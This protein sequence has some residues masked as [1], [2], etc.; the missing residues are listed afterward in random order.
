[1]EANVLR[2]AAKGGT[3]RTAEKAQKKAETSK[4]TATRNPSVATVKGNTTVVKQ[5]ARDRLGKSE[6]HPETDESK[7]PRP[8]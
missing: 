4:G 7:M 2:T 1:M 5:A 8:P 3:P 6:L